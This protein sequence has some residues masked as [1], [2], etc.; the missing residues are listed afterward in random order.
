MGDH[1]LTIPKDSKRLCN[2]EKENCLRVY[3]NQRALIESELSA[4]RVFVERYRAI[5]SY[6]EFALAMSQIS[7]ESP[8]PSWQA[9]LRISD[10]VDGSIALRVPA[11]QTQE[12]AL[13]E[14][15]ADIKSWRRLAKGDGALITQMIAVSALHRKYRLASE[16]MNAYPE[17]VLAHPDLVRSITLPIPLGDANIEISLKSEARS[18]MQLF[19]DMGLERRFVTTTLTKDR[20]PHENL[21]AALIRI[22]YQP[23][24]SINAAYVT[25]NEIV[26]LFAKSP[27]EIVAGQAALLKYQEDLHALGP[28]AIFY[29][30]VG[31]VVLSFD[32]PDYSPYAFRMHDL[33]GLSRL[34]DIQ[35][36][37]IETNIPID[38][39]TDSLPTFGAD[40]MDPYTEKPMQ[41]DPATKSLSFA[42]HGKRYANF[43]VVQ[44]APAK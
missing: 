5:R 44:I 4:K 10:L 20:Q 36:R 9:I 18:S 15:A 34:I 32:F 23:N 16:I 8:L 42:L 27:K 35:R 40:L 12:S 24:A 3:Q 38:K 31:R 43:G 41:W 6:E 2:A 39:V 14:L 21:E 13:A 7:I 19:W 17:L 29:N 37:V 26:T 33:L 1:P 30:P 25:F 11:T 22:A 28:G